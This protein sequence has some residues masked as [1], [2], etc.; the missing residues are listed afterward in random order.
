MHGPA[1]LRGIVRV[2]CVLI[3]QT[4]FSDAPMLLQLLLLLLIIFIG[5]G[6][7][8]GGLHVALPPV[9]FLASGGLR[10]NGLGCCCSVC[11]WRINYTLT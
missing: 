3:K 4:R 5:I 10:H 6:F 7:G 8:A 9:D 11:L 1:H 2:I